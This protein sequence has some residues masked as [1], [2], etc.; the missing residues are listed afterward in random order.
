[1]ALMQQAIKG[2][3]NLA[4]EVWRAGWV[5]H[6]V[7]RKTLP[8]YF[9]YS[10]LKRKNFFKRCL[11]KKCW[12]T[13][14]HI[15]VFT[16]MV[17]VQCYRVIARPFGAKQVQWRFYS[18]LSRLSHWRPRLG[19]SQ[20]FSVLLFVFMLFSQTA[21]L[22]QGFSTTLW[23]QQNC[24][25]SSNV[26]VGGGWGQICIEIHCDP[27]SGPNDEENHNPICGRLAFLQNASSRWAIPHHLYL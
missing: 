9:L 2:H 10:G 8:S 12:S 14:S 25:L 21:T 4:G 7:L 18:G 26:Q 11:W 19:Y 3:N 5:Q 13:V 6:H 22:V 1:M 15:F 23:D 27:H 20:G 24:V 16:A 17:M